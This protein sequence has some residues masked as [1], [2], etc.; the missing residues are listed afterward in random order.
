[1]KKVLILFPIIFLILYF[2]IDL[3]V[4]IKYLYFIK[5]LIIPS[6][7]VFSIANFSNKVTKNF[8]LFSISF[9]V[10]ELLILFSGTN[11]K[12]INYGLLV[13]LFVY[14]VAINFISN[15]LKILHFESFYKKYL[16]LTAALNCMFLG[17]T[18]YVL[19]TSITDTITNYIIILNAILAALLGIIAVLFLNQNI[20]K[21]ALYYF[22][23]VFSML[24][25]DII[26]ALSVFHLD[27]FIVGFVGRLLHFASFFFFF[28]FVINNKTINTSSQLN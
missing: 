5:P 8:Y 20:N 21:S 13:D 17:L 19:R 2:G 6:F 14:S 1:M 7:I 3:F 25:S 22:F 26:G 11:P 23:G 16:I 27:I 4:D 15:F 18:V 28:L 10:A 9:Y 24:L 12:F